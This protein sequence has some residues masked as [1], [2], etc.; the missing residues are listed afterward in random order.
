MKDILDKSG[1][2]IGKI[3]NS[4]E[5]FDS[6]GNLLG[7]IKGNEIVDKDGTKKA[8]INSDEFMNAD[9]SLIMR[10]EG[11]DL[12]DNDMKSIAPAKNKAEAIAAAS[13][14]ILKKKN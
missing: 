2:I 1:N 5:V 7:R 12:V 13:V 10:L 9:G 6:S 4:L 3:N 14:S 8:E 11:E